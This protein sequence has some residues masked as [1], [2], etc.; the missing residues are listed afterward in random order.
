[1][2]ATSPT[3]EPSVENTG[4]PIR[5]AVISAASVSIL[6]GT[7]ARMVV[8]TLTVTLMANASINVP[9]GRRDFPRLAP[10]GAPSSTVLRCLLPTH[11]HKLGACHLVLVGK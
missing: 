1:M 3:A 7:S 11:R 10:E 4:A 2:S 8:G 6:P 9:A 5:S